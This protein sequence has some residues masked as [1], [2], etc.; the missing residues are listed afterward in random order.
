[1]L[2]RVKVI[3]PAAA[4]VAKDIDVSGRSVYIEYTPLYS[5][6]DAVPF[7]K[8][9]DSGSEQPVYPGSTYVIQ[10]H[11]DHFKKLTFYSTAES[12]NNTIRILVSDNYLQE[13]L[14]TNF[15][16]NP[17]AGAGTFKIAST[18]AVQSI[19]AANYTNSRGALAT[20]ML[21]SVETGADIRFSFITNPDQA[22]AGHRLAGGQ[23]IRIDGANF[24][25][26]FKF[27]SAVN[28]SPAQ[29]NFTMQY[30]A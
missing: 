11:C 6:T 9:D 20:S 30:D 17:T 14:Q 24:I 7:F 13:N 27:I 12:I 10:K 1:M 4:N 2:E 29:I 16:T 19:P 5:N 23:F 3:L 25:Q 22:N 26:N 8:F 15:R 21:V 18:D 28:V